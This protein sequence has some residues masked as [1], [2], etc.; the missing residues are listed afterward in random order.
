MARLVLVTGGA[1]S[2]KSRF[3]ERRVFELQPKGP[4]LYIATAEP[5]DDEMKERIQKHRERRGEA[6]R[7]V[8]GP[9]A[10]DALAT[11]N[12]RGVL[13]DCVTLYLSK[14]LSDGLDDERIIAMVE[15]LGATARNFDADVVMV[16]N[17][18]G[19]GVVPETPLGRR[20]R[21]LQGLA[22]QTLAA[23]AHEV[24]LVAAGLPVQLK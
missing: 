3:A 5:V 15:M 4:W 1:R 12:E 20:F 18:V 19:W 22:N 11:S 13:L 7:T 23:M 21:D 17:E 14:L 24:W 2:G 8:E 16:T 6:W 9:H 10:L